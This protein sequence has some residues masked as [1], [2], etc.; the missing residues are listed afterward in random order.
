MKISTPTAGQGVA[1]P[2]AGKNAVVP[3]GQEF[4]RPLL[5]GQGQLLRGRVVGLTPE[6]KVLL[7]IGGRTMEARSEV[8][9]RPGSSLWLEVRQSEPLWLSPA[10]KKGTAQ[11][12]LR[13]YFADPGAMGKGLRALFA[14]NIPQEPPGAGQSGLA[15]AFAG[16]AQGGVAAPESLLRLLTLLGPGSTLQP[17]QA[18]NRLR[19]LAA[20]L[21]Q[22]R[23][24]AGPA[25]ELTALHR[26]GSL[27]E[28]QSELN[29]L[30][31]PSG[32]ALF[33]LF[34]C[35]FAM[36]AGWGQ[37]LFSLA[38]EQE[39]GQGERESVLSF[40]LEMSR[41]GEMQV[42]VRV[43][44]G[45]LYGEFAVATEQV[46]RHLEPRLAELRGLLEGLGYEPVLLSC[47]LAATSLLESLKSGIEHASGLEGTRIIDLLA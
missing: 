3:E 36:G 6:G 45:N 26:L 7:E 43:R 16:V 13:H 18:G 8:A 39:G 9:L 17:G 40:F 38:Q 47:R 30:P 31:G 19:E 2:L 29:A 25:P 10:D 20:Q 32:Q 4:S 35:F 46:L 14:P 34:P 1:A 27:L 22:A 5:L 23:G 33:L 44:G 15:A 41:L 11:E 12:F 24:G 28:L 37:W 42:Q 21:M